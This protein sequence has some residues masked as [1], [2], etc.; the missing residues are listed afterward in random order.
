M[1]FFILY[2]P[3][4]SDK[5]IITQDSQ[6]GLR[7]KESDAKVE[8]LKI[9]RMYVNG[10]MSS[11]SDEIKFFNQHEVAM[12]SGSQK[13]IM[14]LYEE[15]IKNFPI[16]H[17]ENDLEIRELVTNKFVNSISFKDTG[18]HAHVDFFTALIEENKDSKYFF[19]CESVYKAAELIRIG[20]NFTSR[21]M[22][23]IGIGHYTY[24][25]GKNQMV[26]FIVAVGA[27]KGFYYNDAKGIAFE[28]GL[29]LDNRKWQK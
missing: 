15:N 18:A 29:D 12:L 9:I 16:A 4:K 5:M 19:I 17:L 7:F 2:L 22:K 6:L 13:E 26:R 28:F 8:F 27:I 24:L 11:L 10:H 3:N 25:M 1:L 23:D 14:G 20:E 21:T